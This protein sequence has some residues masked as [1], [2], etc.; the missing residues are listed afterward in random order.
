M[1][2]LLLVIDI[3]LFFQLKN[4]TIPQEN[5]SDN[6]KWIV[7]GTMG[8]SWTRKQIEYMEKNK[9]PFEFVDC[10]KKDCPQMEAFPTI[11]TPS[12]QT[13]VGYTEM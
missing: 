5:S 1:L 13:I 9:K 6:K 2:F 11:I 12:G 7:Y 8:C 3:I 10:T 4:Q